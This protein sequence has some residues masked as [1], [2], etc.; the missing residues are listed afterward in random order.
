MAGIE[1]ADDV[2]ME[3]EKSLERTGAGYFDFYLLHALSGAGI[4]EYERLGAWDFVKRMKEEGKIRHSDQ[5]C[6]LGGSGCA[7]TQKLRGLPQIRQAGC[8]H[9]AS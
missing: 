9:G 3:L 1:T 5:L 2:G 8:H 6:R 7:G 4:E